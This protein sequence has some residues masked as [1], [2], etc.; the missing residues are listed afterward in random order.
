MASPRGLP[1]SDRDKKPADHGIHCPYL[2][3]IKIA[4]QCLIRG[5]WQ[6]LTED[7][8]E[9]E[10]RRDLVIALRFLDSKRW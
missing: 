6:G 5:G 1:N 8:D 9:L 7:G 4:D 2:V 10:A 3:A